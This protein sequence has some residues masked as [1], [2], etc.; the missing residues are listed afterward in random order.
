MGENAD[1]MIERSN[2]PGIFQSYR[3]EAYTP[4]STAV[5]VDMTK[6]FMESSRFTNPFPVMPAI[7]CS[8]LYSGYINFKNT[9]PDYWE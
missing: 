6:F 3:I 2:T 4:D 1:D 7:R 8:V 9:V 5:V